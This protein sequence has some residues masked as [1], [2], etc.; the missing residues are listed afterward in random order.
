M[1]GTLPLLIA[2]AAGCTTSD[3]TK[4]HYLDAA[5]AVDATPAVAP[6][7]YVTNPGGAIL[8][9]ASDAT[10]DV[11]PI[12]TI[13]GPSTKLSVPIGLAV[14]GQGQLYV[15]NRTGSAVTVYAPTASGDAA[16]IRTI[17]ATGMGSPE[18]LALGPA[19]DL[20]VATCP[21]CGT[22]AG[23]I[24]GVF[25]VPAGASTSDTSLTGPTTGMTFPSL[26]GDPGGELVVAN[27][28]GGVVGTFAAGATGDAA[29]LRSF[30]PAGSQNIQ[31][32]VAGGGLIALASPVAVT[33]VR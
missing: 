5:T 13:T 15:A 12:R 17:T 23:G 14:D 16:P 6:G 27:S 7:I 11:A 26:A 20:F 29:P 10:G 18:T 24:A 8:V 2:L 9:F 31:G 25:H 19:G 4:H 30:Q 21:G 3:D 32:A 1:R 33:V 22:A 28:F